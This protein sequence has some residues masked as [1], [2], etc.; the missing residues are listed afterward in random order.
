MAGPEAGKK[1][2]AIWPTVKDKKHTNFF[3]F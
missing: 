3:G 2:D 1:A